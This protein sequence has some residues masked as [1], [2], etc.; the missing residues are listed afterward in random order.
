MI[1]CE[2]A[3]QFFETLDAVTSEQNIPREY[4]GGQTLYR[5]ETELLELIERYPAANVSMLSEKFGVTKSAVTQISARLLDKGLIERYKSL[6]NKKERYFRLTEA[7]RRIRAEYADRNQK[8]ADLMCRYL[9]SL[10]G[11][12]KKIILSFMK[13]V[14]S[15]IPLS[16]F[17]CRCG[18]QR[19]ACLLTEQTERTGEA[20]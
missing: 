15:C 1:Q 2:I 10:N 14:R 6:K 18:E 17:P 3:R 11:E 5:A 12:E 19:Q 7:G 8:A 20:C 16:A 9:C 4:S 13:T